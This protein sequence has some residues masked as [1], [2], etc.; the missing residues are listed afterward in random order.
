MSQTER[1]PSLSLLLLIVLALA[2][3]LVFTILGV[4]IAGSIYGFNH[5]LYTISA[6]ASWKRNEI[7]MMVLKIIQICSSFGMFVVPALLFAKIERKNWANYLKLHTTSY[8]LI[9][10]TALI[11]LASMPILEWVTAWN[12]KMEF[13]AILKSIEQWMRNKEDTAKEFVNNLLVMHTKNALL[14]NLLTLAIIP[15]VGE[16]LIFRGCLQRIF[17]R[18]VGNQQAGIWIVAFIFSAIHL[19]F[20]GFLPRMLLGALFGYL[21]LWGGSLY[22]PIFAHFINNAMVVIVSYVYQQQG[23]AMDQFDRTEPSTWYICL[24]S[25]AV[26]TILLYGFYTRSL[27]QRKS[28]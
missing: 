21:L 13:P 6:P 10:L 23:I 15:A 20:F 4:V 11:M 18:W 7:G 12:Q 1:H 8:L 24:V 28:I 5:I 17:S 16:E 26:T 9:V 27:N 19:Q 14:I 3:A 2:G 22:V 25:F